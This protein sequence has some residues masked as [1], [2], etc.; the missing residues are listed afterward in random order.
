MQTN[1]FPDVETKFFRELVP[2]GPNVPLLQAGFSFEPIETFHSS[3]L[4]VQRC[5]EHT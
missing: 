5:V 2:V 1:K 3:M 4:A